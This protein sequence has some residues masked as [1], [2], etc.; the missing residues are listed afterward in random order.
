[1]N[2]PKVGLITFGDARQHE[3]EK[4]FRNLTEPRHRQ[5]IEFF[6]SL[7]IELHFSPDVARTKDEIDEQ[8]DRLKGAS[9]E[10][11]VAHLP[12]WTSPNLV[13]RGVQRMDLPAVLVSNKHPGTHGT[14]GLLGAAGALDQIGFPHLRIR[15]DFGTASI[16]EKTLPFFR[17]ASAASRLKG[18]VLGLFGG[19]S[20]GIDTGTFDPMQWRQMFGVDVEHIDQLEIIRRAGLMAEQPTDTSSKEM[21]A[22]L[23]KNVSSIGYNDQ[24]LTPDKLA[25][26]VRCYLATKEIIEE[27]GLDFVAIKCM[28]DL[29]NHYVPQCISAAFL[30]GPYDA[31]GNKEP[32]AMACEADGDG[33]LTMEILKQVSGGSPV[34]FADL[35]YINEETSTLYLPN[36]GGMCSW[37]A[38]RSDNPVENLSQIE[39][40]PAIRPGGGAIT[41]FTAAPGPV[42][43]ARLY[44]KAGEYYMAI[45]PGEAVEP[46]PEEYEAF[47]KA[48]GSHQ[49]PTAFVRVSL[50]FDEFIDKSGSNHI[51]GVAGIFVQELEHFCRMLDITPVVI[52]D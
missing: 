52:G 46:T 39:L 45:I 21:M 14:V 6:Q 2:H 16:A 17:A 30:P 43:L 32:I 8:V 11:F 34:F 4:L 37:Y 44:R 26:Q 1:M 47:V 22:W 28:P 36:C 35:S 12:C 27:R 40:R 49:L 19:R 42:T 51:S 20:L 38:G 24:G 7:P 9:V 29:T 10:S 48:R 25:F 3:W 13:V 31:Q 23:S 41:Y 18:K 50:D 33:A 15:E 5:A